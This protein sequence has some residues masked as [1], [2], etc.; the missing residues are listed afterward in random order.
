MEE[1]GR[2]EDGSDRGAAVADGCAEDGHA[3]VLVELLWF[4]RC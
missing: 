1:G 4:V 3:A 2:G